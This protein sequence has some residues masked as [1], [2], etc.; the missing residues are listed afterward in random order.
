MTTARIAALRKEFLPLIASVVVLDAVVIVIYYGFHIKAT[1]E[2]TQQTFVGVWL[3]L[4]LLVV[5]TGMKRVRAARL[6]GR[7]TNHE[8]SHETSRDPDAGPDLP[9]RDGA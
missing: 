7:A 1:T 5:T 2:R 6:R 9:S 3:A 8:T 4:T